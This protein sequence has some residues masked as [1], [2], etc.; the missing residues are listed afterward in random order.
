MS[1]PY[2]DGLGGWRGR[3][4]AW[5]NFQFRLLFRSDMYQASVYGITFNLSYCTVQ[6]CIWQARVH[7]L[8]LNFYFIVQVSYQHYH[9]MGAWLNF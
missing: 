2:K 9:C 7:G 8:I 4:R 1:G 3:L 5:R 6:V